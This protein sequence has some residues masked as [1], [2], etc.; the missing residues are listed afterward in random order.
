[1][2]IYDSFRRCEFEEE[3][4]HTY[5]DFERIRQRMEEITLVDGQAPENVFEATG[6]YSKSMEKLLRD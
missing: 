2:A 4:Y 3:I 1:M 6:V 5:V